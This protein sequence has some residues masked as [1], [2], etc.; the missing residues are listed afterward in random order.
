MCEK[1]NQSK[2]EKEAS[3]QEAMRV[4]NEQEAVLTMAKEIKECR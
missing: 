1:G 2:A 3:K 4:F